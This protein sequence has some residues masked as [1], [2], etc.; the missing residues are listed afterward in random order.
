M[1]EDEYLAYVNS[2]EFQFYLKQA[3]GL[4][5]DMNNKSN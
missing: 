1:S 3:K 2:T 4:D 5:D